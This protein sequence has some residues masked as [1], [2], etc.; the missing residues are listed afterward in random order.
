MCTAAAAA[1][2]VQPLPTQG[3]GVPPLALGG[4]LTQHNDAITQLATAAL[5]DA[6]GGGAMCDLSAWPEFHNGVAAGGLHTSRAAGRHPPPACSFMSEHRAS[7][8]KLCWSSTCHI[9]HRGGE[10][11]VIQTGASYAT[12]LCSRLVR[13]CSH[14]TRSA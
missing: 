3:L 5:P 6:A 9:C 7:S 2:T 11:A 14:N 4:R 1:G 8:S 13:Y 12:C 10:V